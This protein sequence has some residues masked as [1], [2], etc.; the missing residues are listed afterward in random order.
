MHAGILVLAATN[1]P[2]SLDE[3]LTRPGR[4][5][6]VIQVPYPSVDGRIDILKVHSRGKQLDEKINWRRVSRAT[7]GFSGAD[8]MNLMNV[9]AI[10][11]VN[12]VGPGSSF[13]LRNGKESCSTVAAMCHMRSWARPSCM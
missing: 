4:F 12:E 1:R 7:A 11:A 9:A 3:A 5:D 13:C 6:R 10:E 2:E 8:L